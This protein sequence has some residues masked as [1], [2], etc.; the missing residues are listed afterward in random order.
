MQQFRR[1]LVFKAHRWSYHSGLGSRV[2]K[3]KRRPPLDPARPP[4]TETGRPAINLLFIPIHFLSICYAYLR[5][6]SVVGHPPTEAGRPAVN[7]PFI[8]TRILTT[9]Y[10]FLFISNLLAIR[11]CSFPIYLLFILIHPISISQAGWRG[12]AR[13][14]LF[15]AGRVAGRGARGG[16]EGA[17]AAQ[18]AEA[19]CASCTHPRGSNPKP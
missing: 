10:S 3:K 12:R 1:G 17:L 16:G 6:A 15:G 9:C 13:A 5:R 2:I 4:P 7:L 8:P 14:R 18:R 19:T 11:S